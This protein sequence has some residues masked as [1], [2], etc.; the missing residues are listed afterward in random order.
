MTS[1]CDLKCFTGQLLVKFNMNEF[2]KNTNFE[3]PHDT[4]IFT[5]WTIMSRICV[6]GLKMNLAR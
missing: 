1:F 3:E 6:D 2:K 5:G 4:H